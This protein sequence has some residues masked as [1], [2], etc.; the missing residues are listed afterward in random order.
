MQL[1]YY[2]V[3]LM[4][5]LLISSLAST[6]GFYRATLCVYSAVFAVVPCPSD[7]LVDCIHVAE[8]IVKLHSRPGS[9][10]NLVS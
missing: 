8:D 7:T 9:S 2:S 4:I 6:D 1:L 5:V 3:Q 10:I